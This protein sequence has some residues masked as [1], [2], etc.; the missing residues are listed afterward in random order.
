MSA[1]FG[2]SAIVTKIE[3]QGCRARLSEENKCCKSLCSPLKTTEHKLAHQIF[4]GRGWFNCWY[5]T[6]D[7]YILPEVNT[8]YSYVSWDGES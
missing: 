4:R 8:V 2:G 1:G 7:F 5:Q 3:V 6:L